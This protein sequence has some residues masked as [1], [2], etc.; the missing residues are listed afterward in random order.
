MDG[1][2]VGSTY[3]SFRR[4]PILEPTFGNQQGRDIA[5]GCYNPDTL[6]FITNV[7]IALLIKSHGRRKG[8][9]RH[10]TGSVQVPFNAST[11]GGHRTFC[12]NMSN[13]MVIIICSNEILI[14]VK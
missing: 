2:P 11:N 13:S 7:Q 8:E 10:F 3:F 5:I 12:S 1:H 9:E 4:V 14:K 6:V